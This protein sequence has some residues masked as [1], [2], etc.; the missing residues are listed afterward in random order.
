MFEDV[1]A[2]VPWHLEE[3]YQELNAHIERHG[4]KASH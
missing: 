3:Q 4:P 1:Y 2:H